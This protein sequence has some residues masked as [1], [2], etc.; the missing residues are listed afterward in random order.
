MEPGG[1]IELLRRQYLQ[2]LNPANLS[3]P[4]PNVLKLPTTQARI[5]DSMFREDSL[6]YP[7]P[8]DYRLRVLKRLINVLERAMD[9]PDEDVRIHP[10]HASDPCPAL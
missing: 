10:F 9:D 7:P 2:L 4:P 3:L 6:V 8:I 5:Y 1:Q